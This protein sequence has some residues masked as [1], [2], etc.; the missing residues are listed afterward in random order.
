VKTVIADAETTLK[1]IA[2]FPDEENWADKNAM[3][4]QAPI[5]P[6]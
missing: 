5:F 1:L 2:N 4:Q 6:G 3:T